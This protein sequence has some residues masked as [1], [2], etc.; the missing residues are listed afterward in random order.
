MIMHEALDGLLSRSDC[1]RAPLWLARSN[2]RGSRAPLAAPLSRYGARVRTE[3]EGGGLR[4]S[5]AQ[6]PASAAAFWAKSEP[7]R[8]YLRTMG[9]LLCPVCAMMTRSDVP[10]AAADVARPARSECPA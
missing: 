1:H 9:R 6:R 3:R 2:R 4:W 10:A 7:S 8:I 5:A